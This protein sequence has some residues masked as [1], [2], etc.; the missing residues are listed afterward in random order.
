M[1][2]SCPICFRFIYVAFILSVCH[3]A[4]AEGQWRSNGSGFVLF[5][6]DSSN[7]GSSA[8]AVNY[9]T[10]PNNDHTDSYLYSQ[11]TNSISGGNI[12]PIATAGINGRHWGAWVWFNDDPEEDTLP[13]TGMPDIT[14]FGYYG[15]DINYYST[16]TSGFSSISLD[17]LYTNSLGQYG[18]GLSLSR[19]LSSASRGSRYSP[20]ATQGTN[21]PIVGKPHYLLNNGLKC[22]WSIDTSTQSMGSGIFFNAVSTINIGVSL[23]NQL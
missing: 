22:K 10:D 9:F 1:R 6:L 3:S 23:L 19:N 4:N 17:T 13:P 18:I 15:I 2:S 5:S 14:V 8:L 11:A 16:N 7:Q 21:T 20:I 12:S